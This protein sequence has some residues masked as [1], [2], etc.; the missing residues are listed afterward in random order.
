MATITRLEEN[1]F[2]A[3]S[4]EIAETHDYDW[5]VQ[6]IFPDENVTVRNVTDEYGVL[7]LTDPDSRDVLSKLTDADLSNQE[8]PWLRGK[9][10]DVSGIQTR[11]LRVSY[12][13]ELGWELHLPKENVSKQYDK[14]MEAGA[15]FGIVNF[16]T[17]VV[18]SLRLEKASDGAATLIT[19]P[20]D[21]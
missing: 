6:H 1:N 20:I 8:F 12:A 13:G 10:I 3:L 21:K 2:Y 17:Y 14:L 15:E 5:L 9:S 4:G 11:A 7:V 18:N 19:L 16:G